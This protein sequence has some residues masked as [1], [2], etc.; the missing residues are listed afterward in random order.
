MRDFLCKV[1]TSSSIYSSQPRLQTSY[2]NKISLS[3]EYDPNFIQLICL[4]RLE[5]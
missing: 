3:E 4:H 1:I 5:E 2:L